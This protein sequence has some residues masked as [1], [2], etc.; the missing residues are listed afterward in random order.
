MQREREEGEGEVEEVTGFC[1][2]MYS[3]GAAQCSRYLQRW[4]GRWGGVWWGC[5]LRL[6]WVSSL[7]PRLEVRTSSTHTPPSRVWRYLGST[8]LYSRGKV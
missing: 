4:I 8:S 6:Q 3:F 2:A 5:S 1:V 7:P